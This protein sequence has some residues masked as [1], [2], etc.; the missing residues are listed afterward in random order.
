MKADTIKALAKEINV[1]AEALKATLKLGTKAAAIRSM[2]TFGRK[3]AMDRD[4]SERSL[5][6]NPNRSWYPPYN[7]WIEDQHELSS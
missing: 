7:G 4:L 5:L 2:L 6:R 1:P 3:T